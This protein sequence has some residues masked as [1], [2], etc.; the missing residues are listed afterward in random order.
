[1]AFSPDDR[2]ALSGAADQT[3]ILWDVASGQPLRRYVGHA[4]RVS[5]VAFSPDG[6]R[7]ASTG[8]DTTLRLWTITDDLPALI[9]WT[10]S[11][12]HVR[13]LTPE[14][15]RLYGAEAVNLGDVRP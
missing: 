4:D 14:E 5:G 9:D 6:G 2:L 7:A 1:M 15:R 12:R 11:N 10:Y 3:V 8:W 13:T